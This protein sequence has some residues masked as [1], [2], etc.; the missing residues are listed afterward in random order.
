VTTLDWIALGFAALTAFVGFRRGLVATALSL[1]GLLVGAVVGALVAPHLLRGG[2]DSPYTALVALG[3]ATVGA[4]LGKA[5][6]GLIGS[7]VHGGLR[8][9][10]PLRTIDSLGGLAAGAAFGLALVWIAAAVALQL[11]KHSQVRET[12]R[13]SQVVQQL[14]RLAPPR[15]VLRLRA[16]LQSLPNVPS[17]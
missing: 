2:S 15:D 6:A 3:G 4:I 7:L 1:A 10:P 8:L 16:E 11:P 13:K 5:V 14:D 12:V 17:L 9:L